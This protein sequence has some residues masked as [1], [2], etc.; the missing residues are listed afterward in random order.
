VR[1]HAAVRGGEVASSGDRRRHG[2]RPAT[3]LGRLKACRRGWRGAPAVNGQCGLPVQAA[4]MRAWLW[5]L[6]TWM[7]ARSDRAPT[8]QLSARHPTEVHSDRR[9]DALTRG[10][11]HAWCSAARRVEEECGLGARWRR[12]ADER[13]RARRGATD[14]WAPCGSFYPKLK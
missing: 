11:A 13:A 2:A 9:P 6:L 1:L 3:Q 12:G 8:D 14:R 4:S 5:R 10:C 7:V